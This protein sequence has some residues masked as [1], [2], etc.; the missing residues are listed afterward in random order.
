MRRAFSISLAA[1]AILLAGCRQHRPRLPDARPIFLA[2]A[3]F[4]ER[5]VQQGYADQ[6]AVYGVRTSYHAV[7]PESATKD[8]KALLADFPEIVIYP[9]VDPASV[10]GVAEQAYSHTVQL[11]LVGVGDPDTKAT[12]VIRA[13]PD[14]LTKKVAG[15]VA[16]IL[17]KGGSVCFAA[18]DNTWIDSKALDYGLGKRWLGGGRFRLVDDPEKAGAIVA[19]GSG[20]L[21]KVAGKG[22]VIAVACG[23]T[24]EVALKR[25]DA[26]ILLE[27]NW[28]VAGAVAARLVRDGVDGGLLSALFYSIPIEVIR[29]RTLEEYRRVR[30]K[31]LPEDG[32]TVPFTEQE[33]KHLWPNRKQ[34]GDNKGKD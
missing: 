32:P 34:E 12:A 2:G 27:P 6:I 30:N 28:Y 33:R 9:G 11:Y 25:G 7:T 29:A 5:Q 15:A 14:E 24:G 13:D 20:A 23:E 17:P 10:G 21:A 1:A 4:V 19:V 16:G 18:D 3:G 8:F 22:R 31:L 26:E